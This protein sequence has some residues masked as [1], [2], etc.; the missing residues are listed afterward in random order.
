MAGRF[1]KAAQDGML[2][3]LKEA[4][5]K[6]TNAKDE[7]GMTP[8]L[9]A[10]H[11][12]HLEALRLL[13]GR[14]GDIEKANYHFGQTALHLAAA[15]GHL[16][17][18]SFL[19]GFEANLFALDHDLHTP[20]QVATNPDVI[21]FLDKAATSQILA[22]KKE[23]KAKK[24]KALKDAE[25]RRKKYEERMKKERDKEE[26]RMKKVEKEIG[27]KIETDMPIPTLPT[28]KKTV[29]EVKG[30]T[31]TEIVGGTMSKK[32]VSGVKKILE[33][34]IRH[35]DDKYES[36]MKSS[37][38]GHRKDAQIIYV[39][40]YEN[41][42][43]GKRGKISDVFNNQ[44]HIQSSIFD[45]PGFGSVA[46]RQRTN[47]AGTLSGVPD[48]IAEKDGDEEVSS[49]TSIGSAG[50]LANRSRHQPAW[51]DDITTSDEENIVSNGQWSPLERFLVS[52][53]VEE[54]TPR[55]LAQKIDLEA[56]LMLTDLDLMQ[57]G[58]PMGPRR[59]LLH[60]VEQRKKALQNPGLLQ[61]TKL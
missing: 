13:V 47:L 27:T 8:T 3:I 31:F 5:K 19:V 49:E 44:N 41:P 26:K 51:Q 23:V 29:V 7:D 33:K 22:N 57:L 53:G 17:C 43:N 18:V 9:W 39:S 11:S 36:N 59:K 30:P 46:F 25:R 52:A 42:N 14:G 55:L 37:I 60:A 10:A 38:G 28:M 56:V 20:L 34:K 21:D 45:R 15:R 48:A 32:P 61:D 12:G 4:T 16:N 54:Y 2:E 58:V 35:P 40:S 6:D 50:S 1:H 24:E